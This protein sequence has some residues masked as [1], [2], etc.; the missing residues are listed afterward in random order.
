MATFTA[1]SNCCAIVLE[2][3]SSNFSLKWEGGG[4]GE[5]GSKEG[6]FNH[7]LTRRR[8]RGFETSQVNGG[9]EREV[10]PLLNGRRGFKRG[11]KG[12]GKG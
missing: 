2:G 12:E 9:V 4:R 1:G 8:E 10:Q 6:R 3:E 7:R 11:V 5:E